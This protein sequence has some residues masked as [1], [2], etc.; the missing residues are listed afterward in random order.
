MLILHWKVTNSAMKSEEEEVYDAVAN[1][2]GQC[3]VIEN[4]YLF[5]HK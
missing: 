5:A 2:A 1:I 4:K 3:K